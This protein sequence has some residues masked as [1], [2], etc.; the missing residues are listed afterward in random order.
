MFVYTIVRL[1]KHIKLICVDA[2]IFLI[3][4]LTTFFTVNQREVLHCTRK[5]I[6][7]IAL[8]I[9]TH[10]HAILRINIHQVVDYLTLQFTFALAFAFAFNALEIRRLIDAILI[11]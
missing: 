8:Y 10:S 6:K 5:P 1:F 2:S 3:D 11:F 7:Q 4:N 9:A